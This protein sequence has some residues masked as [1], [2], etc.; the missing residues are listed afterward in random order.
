MPGQDLKQVWFAGVHADIGGGYSEHRSGLSK[1]TLEWMIGE[2][3]SAGL[4][5]NEILVAKLLGRDESSIVRSAQ[6]D[7]LA[8]LHS[9]LT[10]FFWPMEFL[11]RR[12]YDTNKIPPLRVW[13][14]PSGRRRRIP[15]GAVIHESVVE[16]MRLLPSYAP[17]NPPKT[18]AVER[19]AASVSN[20]VE[21]KIM[22]ARF[23]N[24]WVDSESREI[25]KGVWYRFN[26][27][28]G[29]RGVTGTEQRLEHSSITAGSSIEVLVSLFSKDFD[30]Q[31]RR[32]KLSLATAGISDRFC[33]NVKAKRDGPCA[34]EIVITSSDSL[35]ILQRATAEIV[36]GSTAPDILYA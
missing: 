36:V 14:I 11:P 13:R 31:E 9:S 32:G 22:T 17:P 18:Y 30:I 7:P 27:N 21:A 34:I 24:S 1:I 16:R 15:E 3:R 23:V 35:D 5:F 12:V 6:P 20:S 25:N 2:A 4:L 26:I 29:P 10:G 28:I 8:T 19:T 33:T